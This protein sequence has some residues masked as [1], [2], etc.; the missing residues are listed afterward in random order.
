MEQGS[1]W[2]S[3]AFPDAFPDSLSE[4]TN[5]SAASDTS[6]YSNAIANSSAGANSDTGANP[7][8]HSGVDPQA[9]P[10][11]HTLQRNRDG[12]RCGDKAQ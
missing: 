5:S 11:G 12:I 8:S 2:N 10:H 3:P 7:T 4:A 9:S 1:C 6:F